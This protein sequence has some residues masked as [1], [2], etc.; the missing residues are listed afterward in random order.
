MHN[1]K[2]THYFCLF[3]IFCS[4]CQTAYFVIPQNIKHGTELLCSYF[5]CRNAGI[6]FRYCVYC[7]LP[8]AKRNFAKRHRH[9]GKI[10][11]NEGSDDAVRGNAAESSA[12]DEP[13]CTLATP[14]QIQEP[15][16]HEKEA[17]GDSKADKPTEVETPT[18]PP[19]TVADSND[20]SEKAVSQSSGDEGETPLANP[21]T[22]SAKE[23]HVLDT[24]G[25]EPESG[26]SK[27]ASPTR[28]PSPVG[29]TP[30]APIDTSKRR[31]AWG[32]LL[33]KRPKTQQHNSEAMTAWIRDVLRVS[34]FETDV[35]SND[36][37]SKSD[38]QRGATSP[39]LNGGTK[40]KMEET[41]PPSAKKSK[42][43]ALLSRKEQ[44]DMDNNTESDK[45]QEVDEKMASEDVSNKVSGKTY[46]VFPDDAST[47]SDESVDLRARKKHQ[48]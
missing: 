7:K 41:R 1:I 39:T 11:N 4:N 8:V 23:I 17:S 30:E 33:L 21:E 9:S 31:A 6:K 32:D 38:I 5:A 26:K 48:N 40:R 13:R 44:E 47:S 35:E 16:T 27:D 34:D 12:D 25:V 42:K 2:L 19:E 43:R 3:T 28:E 46:E 10:P 37:E 22:K 18:G 20:S 29:I 36:D 14:Q 15:R 24:K 45:A